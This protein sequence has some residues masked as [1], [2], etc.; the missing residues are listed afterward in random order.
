MGKK[1]GALG[2]SPSPAWLQSKSGDSFASALRLLRGLRG[3]ERDVDLDGEGA[4]VGPREPAIGPHRPPLGHRQ[5]PVP[6][7][8]QP[9]QLGG[10]AR[11]HP[12]LQFALDGAV[13]GVAHGLGH[14]HHPTTGAVRPDLSKF[15]RSDTS[16][17]QPPPPTLEN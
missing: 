15:S 7:Q 11:Q 12:R 8:M 5:H 9:T 3:A 17:H 4:R 16:N 2:F 14:A 1:V 13:G 10:Q 6:L